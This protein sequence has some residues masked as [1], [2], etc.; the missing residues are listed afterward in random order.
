MSC[1]SALNHGTQTDYC[2]TQWLLSEKRCSYAHCCKVNTTMLMGR[3]SSRVTYSI[4]MHPHSC[5]TK[6]RGTG[7]SGST[8]HTEE[9]ADA[10]LRRTN[11]HIQHRHACTAQEHALNVKLHTQAVWEIA[12]T[13]GD[14]GKTQCAEE[15]VNNHSTSCLAAVAVSD[16]AFPTVSVNFALHLSPRPDS[17]SLSHTKRQNHTLLATLSSLGYC[18]RRALPS[19]QRQKASP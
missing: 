3:S 2:T 18:S 17:L 15:H 19:P 10:P 4:S 8:F 16:G 1:S 14:T 12:K 7:E 5:W 11:K 13:H 9:V 6:G